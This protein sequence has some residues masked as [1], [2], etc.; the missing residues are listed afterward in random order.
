M[1]AIAFHKEL[2]NY[3]NT[4]R[5]EFTAASIPRRS[6]PIEGLWDALFQYWF[7]AADLEAES[8]R[9]G[10]RAWSYPKRW[11]RNTMVS[12]V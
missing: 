3:A 9:Y 6:T 1:K 2:I 10:A 7:N 5:E 12:V 4:S 8:G 11:R